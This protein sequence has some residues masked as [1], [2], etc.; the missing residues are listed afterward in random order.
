MEL[1]VFVFNPIREN[2]YLLWDNSCE[3]VIV[4]AG[5]Y[6]DREF[7]KLDSFIKENNLKPVKLLNTHCHF[8]HL[9]GVERCRT[10]YGID[11]EISENDAF[12]VETSVLQASMFGFKVSE[13]SPAEAYLKDG[14]EICFGESKLKVISV[15]G[16]SPGGICFYNE[17]SKILLTGDSL[18]YRSIGRTDLP[19]GNYQELISGLK[20]KI[21]ILP[22][23]VDVFPGHE[24][25]T[26]IGDEKALNPFLR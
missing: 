12:L 11:W 5:C 13:I 21:L 3:C 2:T 26:T 20:N 17:E 6:N 22:D 9:L 4:D 1:K 15:P 24:S 23:D 8:D 7:E 14:D 18:F 10:Q 19:G 16:H 25:S